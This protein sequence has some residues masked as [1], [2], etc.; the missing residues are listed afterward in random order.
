MQWVNNWAMW[1]LLALCIPIIIHL[2]NFRRYKKI[3][4]SNVKVLQQL[5]QQT[6]QQSRLKHLLVLL[7]RL[8]ALFF[9]ILAF[10]QPYFS[11]KKNSNSVAKS[12]S[13]YIDN[14]MSMQAGDEISLLNL[15]KIKAK[16][17][18]NAYNDNI[19]FQIISND[20]VIQSN[21]FTRKQDASRLIDEIKL[22]NN[23]KKWSEANTAMDNAFSNIEI[24][25]KVKY[26]IG[27][28]QKI[29]SDIENLKD[30]LSAINIAL[31][32]NE[33]KANV[34]ID[35]AWLFAPI[36]IEG[37]T[38]KAFAK[39][40][41]Y[42]TSTIQVKLDFKV[43]DRIRQTKKID[44]SANASII[45]T[46]AFNSDN[47]VWQKYEFAIN[48]A[49]FTFD[50]RYFLSAKMNDK[51]QILAINQT[52]QKDN[53]LASFFKKENSIQLNQIS[54]QQINYNEFNKS[55]LIILNQLTAISSGF[56]NEL[57]KYL[58]NGG[59]IMLLPNTD[60]SSIN[61][62]L[63]SL[64][65]PKLSVLNTVERK[66]SA[67]NLGNIWLNDV[68]KNQSGITLPVFKKYYTISNS[69]LPQES[70]LAFLDKSNAIAKV[71]CSNGN[72]ILFCT[73]LL[74]SN[75]DIASSS[76]LVPLIFNIASHQNFN[77]NY[78]FI[79]GN[80]INIALSD[81][82]IL[83]NEQIKV[84]FDNTE[85]S[86]PF[87]NTTE[88]LTINATN[89]LIYTGFYSFYKMQKDEKIF[90]AAVNLNNQESNLQCYTYDELK[91]KA[92]SNITINDAKKSN[93][94]AAKTPFNNQNFW[95]LSLI[96]CL[97]FL[98]IE[99]LLIRFYK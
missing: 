93:I 24:E 69:V 59:N 3:Q 49:P 73:N 8:F 75:S 62:W 35:S 65:A 89:A 17:I 54:L 53:I 13:I 56:I 26:F 77:N 84:K 79:L 81:N 96:I 83:S 92:S 87:E 15:A 95:K 47:Q 5:L 7:S 98:L 94:S 30:T 16:D 99:T 66:S 10:A 2:F 28:G 4:F 11:N 78:N 68:Y 19:Q 71:S 97:I 32:Q 23:L 60:N 64:N 37:Q 61:I 55:N 22:S 67:L 80:K 46:I 29:S 20:N 31:I 44:I 82:N 42:G 86:V 12:V 50:N 33:N 70:I 58:K 74:S 39:I 52:S 27:D 90:Q 14:S 18:L 48:D 85:F 9:L 36:Q 51:V 45:D 72:I 88:K 1:A 34:G 63:S 57:N 43:N 38:I 41:N 6:Q 91:Q 40:T 76:F 25:N 21:F